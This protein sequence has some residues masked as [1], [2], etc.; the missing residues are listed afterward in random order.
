MVVVDDIN[1]G[2]RHMVLQMAHRDDLVMNAVLAASAFH[3]SSRRASGPQDAAKLYTRAIRE[4]QKKRTI[5]KYDLETQH[6]IIL[7]I[8]VLLV[9]LMVNGSSDFPIVFQMLRSALVAIG[10]DSK[11]KEGE[12]PQFLLRQIHK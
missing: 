5:D 11:L 9:A 6:S 7:A 1:N 10:G 8:L 3:F 2:W 4:L 12:L